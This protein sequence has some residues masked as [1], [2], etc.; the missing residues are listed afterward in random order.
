VLTAPRVELMTL[1]QKF[2]DD[3]VTNQPCTFPPFKADDW[4]FPKMN[5]ILS[6]ACALRPALAC[7][8]PNSPPPRRVYCDVR[9][10]MK[11]TTEYGFTFDNRVFLSG[12]M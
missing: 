10:E 6:K 5:P 9:S 8:L 11:V 1:K 4:L 2:G 12:K 3:C 7:S